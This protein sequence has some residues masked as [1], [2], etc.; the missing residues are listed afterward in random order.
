MLN[1][2]EEEPGEDYFSDEAS[3]QEENND[4]DK[5]DL[6]EFINN[7]ENKLSGLCLWFGH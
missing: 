7:Y 4:E 3:S 1:K 6:I 2:V 5:K